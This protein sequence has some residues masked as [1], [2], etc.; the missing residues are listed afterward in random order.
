MNLSPETGSHYPTAESVIANSRARL[1]QLG[2]PNVIFQAQPPD[3]RMEL[4]TGVLTEGVNV[5][6]YFITATG[7]DDMQKL[8]DAANASYDLE[9]SDLGVKSLEVSTD[10]YD[11]HQKYCNILGINPEPQI[12]TT[13]S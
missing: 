4:T 5:P 9:L 10:N 2:I 11:T 3:I 1:E 12:Q 13:P 6:H 8:N 7:L